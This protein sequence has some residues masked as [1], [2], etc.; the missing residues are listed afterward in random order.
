MF[1]YYISSFYYCS[2]YFILYLYN[3]Y[4]I[5]ITQDYLVKI[6][7][8]CVHLLVVEPYDNNK[9]IIFD[10]FRLLRKK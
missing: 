4:Y 8:S 2:D 3:T 5:N 7:T 9:I 10:Y 1:N 6:I